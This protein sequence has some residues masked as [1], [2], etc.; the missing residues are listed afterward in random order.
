MTGWTGLFEVE[1]CREAG[2][3]DF[4][5]QALPVDFLS[6]LWKMRSKSSPA[7]EGL[8]QGTVMRSSV[9]L[10]A[11]SPGNPLR[12]RSLRQMRVTAHPV[13]KFETTAERT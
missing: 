10:S 6:G 2:F 11:A 8:H 9:C 7:G 1:E 12:M 13:Q 3:D 5:I 4:F